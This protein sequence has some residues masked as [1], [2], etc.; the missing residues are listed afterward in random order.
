MVQEGALR[1]RKPALS[2]CLLACVALVSFEA[3][4][5]RSYPPLRVPPVAELA[6][7]ADVVAVV[8]V[9]RIRPLTAE[10]A[11]F[12][13]RTYANPPLNV[14]V[15]FPSPSAEFTVVRTLKGSVPAS[16]PLRA[17]ADSCEVTLMQGH[18]YLI[19]ARTPHGADA[20]IVP[21][22]GTFAIDRSQSSINALADVQNSL[23]SSNPTP[24]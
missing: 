19:F 21:L 10:E 18:D 9:S 1:H 15:R 17:G 13:E 8:H 3:A 22:H 11:A 23:L 5:C 20:E 2:A 4:A 16:L 7:S 24:P 6:R 12:T 14:E